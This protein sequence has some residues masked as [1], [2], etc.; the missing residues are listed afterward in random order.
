[1]EMKLRPL[2]MF[3]RHSLPFLKQGINRKQKELKKYTNANLPGGMCHGIL[4]FWHFSHGDSFE[5][6]GCFGSRDVSTLQEVLGGSTT[7]FFC[8]SAG[9][10]G[11][12]ET[13]REK[14]ALEGED[15]FRPSL[16]TS[17]IPLG[18]EPVFPCLL[19]IYRARIFAFWIS[20]ADIGRL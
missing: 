15:L 20:S 10:E 8:S 7:G 1:M 9:W 16:F 14:L 12:L 11:T 17:F 2:R 18:E 13:G 6:T 5:A 19:C 4:T 3:K